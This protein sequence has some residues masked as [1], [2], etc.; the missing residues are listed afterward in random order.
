M[1]SIVCVYN[2]K[3]ILSSYL[4]KSLEIQ[5]SEYELILV[6]NTGGKF[7]SAAEALNYGGKLANNNYIIFIHQDMDLIS[8]NWLENVE[9]L[10]NTLTNL[11]IAGVAGKSKDQWWPLTN[12][13]DGIPP[14]RVSPYKITIPMK[15]QTLDECLLIIPKKIFNILSFDKVTCDD[16]HLYGVD[17]CLT[18]KKLGYNVYVLPLSGHHKS[19]GESISERY[20]ETLNKLLKKHRN[21][22]L[23][24]TT[25]D[26]W[27]TFLPLNIQRKFPFIKRMIV[28]FLRRF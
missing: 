28:S 17:F 12:I 7:K 2:N 13:E 18:I 22:K 5:I 8:P 23:I 9:D 24:F 14:Q 19:K 3:A 20:F 27:L 4:L 10:L 26:D 6:D 1:I 16:W 11:G 21:H 25:V 15:V